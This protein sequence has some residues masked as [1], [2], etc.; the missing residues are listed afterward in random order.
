MVRTPRIY[1]AVCMYVYMLV[2]HSTPFSAGKLQVIHAVVGSVLVFFGTFALS[3]IHPSLVKLII[4]TTSLT[5]SSY[6]VKVLRGSR[7]LYSGLCHR[8]IHIESPPQHS[9]I[10]AVVARK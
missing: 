1:R 3:I 5:H 8:I 10:D 2:Y 9:S 6:H 4:Q 7:R